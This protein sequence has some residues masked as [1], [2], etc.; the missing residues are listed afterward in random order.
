MPEIEM[1]FAVVLLDPQRPDIVVDL[2]ANLLWEDG[3]PI[4]NESGLGLVK[5]EQSP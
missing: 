4:R 2:F 3:T 5:L 1:P